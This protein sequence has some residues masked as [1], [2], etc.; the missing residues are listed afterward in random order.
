MWVAFLQIFILIDVLIIGL[1]APYLYR[2]AR[3]HFK[4]EQHDAHAE[5]ADAALPAAVKARILKDSEAKF[6]AVVNHSIT[7]LQHNLQHTTTEVN[8]MI[9]KLSVDVVNNELE[10]YRDGLAKLHTQAE[11]DLGDFKQKMEGHETEMK[12]KLADEMTVEKQRLVKQLDTKLGD[13][14]SSFLLDTLQ[15]N[16]DLGSQSAYLLSVLEEHK[17]EFI[18][19]VSD[20]TP[21]A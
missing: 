19:E 13:A 10:Q 20:E 3:A 16:V 6:E 7:E 9:K 18:K 4:P 12:Q 14:V 5:N 15:H 21:T 17:A 8:T 11:K 2:H 1:L